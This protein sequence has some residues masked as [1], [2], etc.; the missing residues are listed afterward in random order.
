MRNKF[1]LFTVL[2]YEIDRQ[3]KILETGGFV[4]NETRAFDYSSK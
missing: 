2:D 3:I 1:L 4:S